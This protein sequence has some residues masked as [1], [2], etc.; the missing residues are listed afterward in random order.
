MS[1]DQRHSR[2]IHNERGCKNVV[3]KPRG[4]LRN[5]VMYVYVLGLRV[6]G[7]SNLLLVYMYRYAFAG[8]SRFLCMATS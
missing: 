6:P 5:F 8:K 1:H 2:V 3:V 4:V 7:V